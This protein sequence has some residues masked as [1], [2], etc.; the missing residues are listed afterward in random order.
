MMS[1]GDFL[2]GYVRY[3]TKQHL[4][5]SFPDAGT[6]T[7]QGTTFLSDWVVTLVLVSAM[8]AQCWLY[9][10]LYCSD[11]GWVK[12]G[13]PPEGPA[14]PQCGYCGCTPPKRSR[15][16]FNTGDSQ[17]GTGFQVTSKQ[18]LSCNQYFTPE[19]QA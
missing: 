4:F 18:D 1:E 2:G 6:L 12:T 17:P 9:Y 5:M 10:R 8:A 13:A 15:H 19:V 11:P 16:D 3:S 14:G 7:A